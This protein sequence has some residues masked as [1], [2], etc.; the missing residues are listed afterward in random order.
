MLKVLSP[1]PKG[2]KT[3]KAYDMHMQKKSW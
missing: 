1:L 3:S 2:S